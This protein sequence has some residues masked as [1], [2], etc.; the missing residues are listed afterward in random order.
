MADQEN[1]RG[2]LRL[3]F[4]FASAFNEPLLSFGVIPFFSW[5]PISVAS[6]RVGFGHA[7]QQIEFALARQSSKRAVANF[8]SLLIELAGLQMIAHQ[9]DYLGAHVIPIQRVNIQSI[10]K[11]LSRRNSGLFVFARS[12]PPFDKGSRGRFAE[13]VTERSQHHG[14]LLRIRQV[15]DDLAY[16][17]QGTV[18]LAP[19]E[20]E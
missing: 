17:K 7:I 6:E 8:V 15:I 14:H 4:E 11:A 9:R 20:R 12:N 3:H 1:W 19:P 13:I 5:H 16:A 10:E 2:R 18:M